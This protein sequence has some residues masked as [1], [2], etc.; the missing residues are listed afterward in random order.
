MFLI[1]LCLSFLCDSE[2]GQ[3][4]APRTDDSPKKITIVIFEKSE[5]PEEVM[6]KARQALSQKGYKLGLYGVRNSITQWTV[7]N[8]TYWRIFFRTS[9]PRIEDATLPTNDLVVWINKKTGETIV[10]PLFTT[11]PSGF[12]QALKEIY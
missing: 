2:K 9:L 5:V 12:V 6:E 4:K 8:D 3:T 10:G 11:V 7:G 1:L